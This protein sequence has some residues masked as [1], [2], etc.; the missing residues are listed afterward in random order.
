LI[1]GRFRLVVNPFQKS[2]FFGLLCT[3]KKILNFQMDKLWITL[4]KK[5]LKSCLFGVG[6]TY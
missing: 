3:L 5:I 2:F 4:W 6:S 1:N